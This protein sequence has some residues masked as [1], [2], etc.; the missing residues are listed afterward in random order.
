MNLVLEVGM[1]HGLGKSKCRAK[2]AWR[3]TSC[4]NVII[5][6]LVKPCLQ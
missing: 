2:L 5:D 3:D 4:I 1:R 6:L